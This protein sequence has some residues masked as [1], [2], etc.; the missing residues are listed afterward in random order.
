MAVRKQGHKN[1]KE[2]MLGFYFFYMVFFTIFPFFYHLLT[3]ME[4]IQPSADW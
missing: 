4:N 3:F 2:T 1:L